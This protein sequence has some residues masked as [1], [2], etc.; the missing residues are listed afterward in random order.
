MERKFITIKIGINRYRRVFLDDIL[1]CKADRAYSIIKTKD[2]EYTFCEP[3]KNIEPL[4][5]MHD[6]F[7]RVNR[8]FIANLT[9]CIEFKTGT[10]P[11]L[12]YRKWNNYTSKSRSVRA[13]NGVF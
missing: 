6:S 3:L 5:E 8:S 7:L 4:F 10:K 1:Y 13:N 9:K 12:I 11:E 2:S